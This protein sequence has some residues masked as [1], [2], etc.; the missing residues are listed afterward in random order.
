M[1][2]RWAPQPI[3]ANLAAP[4]VPVLTVNAPFRVRQVVAAAVAQPA[5]VAVVAVQVHEA[6]LEGGDNE[7]QTET[8]QN[9]SRGKATSN[10]FGEHTGYAP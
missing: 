10:C 3:Q 9:T 4:V 7:N 6:F 8:Q 1:T 5:L 2:W